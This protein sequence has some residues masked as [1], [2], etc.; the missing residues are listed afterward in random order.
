MIGNMPNTDIVPKH[1]QE[2][3]MLLAWACDEQD[4]TPTRWKDAARI[5]A[6]CLLPALATAAAI[7]IATP[8]EQATAVTA[9]TTTVTV[10]PPAPEAKD[11]AFLAA[12]Q[13]HGIP[14]INKGIA[15]AD[16]H[17]QCM[18]MTQ[19]GTTWGYQ[20]ES[21]LKSNAFNQDQAAQFLVLSTDFYC[22]NVI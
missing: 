2:T 3:D 5:A 1:V 11:E 17:I 16:G 9:T 13:K 7:L 14:I 4:E 12:L 6:W 18:N 8:H 21:I 10:T 22:P 15:I 20:V 19:A